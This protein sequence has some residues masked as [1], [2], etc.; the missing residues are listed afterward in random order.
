MHTF[1]NSKLIIT[2]DSRKLFL[3]YMAYFARN[4]AWTSS[5]KVMLVGKKSVLVLVSL[6][7]LLMT[8]HPFKC[9]IFLGPSKQNG[10][11]SLLRF[12]KQENKLRAYISHKRDS[13]TCKIYVCH[14]STDINNIYFPNIFVLCS[15]F[16]KTWWMT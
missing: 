3:S 10:C 16:C 6:L 7:W 4:S 9:E 1:S 5:W 14:I 8:S 2:D 13:M 11:F 15:I 12:H